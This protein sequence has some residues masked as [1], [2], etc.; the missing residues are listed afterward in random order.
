MIRPKSGRAQPRT[1]QYKEASEK[2]LMILLKNSKSNRSLNYKK[3]ECY[4]KIDVDLLCLRIK[5]NVSF[6]DQFIKNMKKTLA[7]IQSMN[8]RKR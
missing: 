7:E 6:V 8:Q 3:K 1:F 5:Q 4:K 2:R